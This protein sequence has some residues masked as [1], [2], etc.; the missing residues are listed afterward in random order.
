MRTSKDLHQFVIP[1][2]DS[3]IEPSTNA[4][5]DLEGQ[6][7]LNLKED[8]DSLGNLSEILEDDSPSLKLKEN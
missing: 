5:Q 3:P 8:M 2:E 1:E 7:Q 6:A 4:L